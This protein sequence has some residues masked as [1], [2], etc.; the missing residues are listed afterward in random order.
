MPSYSFDLSAAMTAA[1]LAA[2]L[3]VVGSHA[4]NN[5]RS[6]T[7][8]LR[9]LTGTRGQRAALRV[10]LTPV[11]REFIPLLDRAGVDVRA[12]VVVPTLSGVETEPLAAEIE[13]L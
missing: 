6:R 10:A 9:M 7:L 2:F 4:L 13:R 11:L 1:V 12:V 8:R 5:Y 3:L